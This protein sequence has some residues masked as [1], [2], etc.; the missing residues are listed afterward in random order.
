MI[1]LPPDCLGATKDAIR[2]DAR[3]SGNRRSRATEHEQARLLP[4]RPH[5]SSR[6]S[7]AATSARGEHTDEAIDGA[8]TR[9]WGRCRHGRNDTQGLWVQ[10]P[11]TVPGVLE[12][13]PITAVLL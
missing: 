5:T 1:A 8:I 3:R 7:A 11:V 6:S 2:G 13:K 9:G 10:I 4:T 12:N